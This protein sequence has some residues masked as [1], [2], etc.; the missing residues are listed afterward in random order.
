[1]NPREWTFWC[2][3]RVWKD[4]LEPV[5]PI[6]VTPI[7]KIFKECQVDEIIPY[8][9]VQS[10]QNKI[11]CGWQLVHVESSHSSGF[12]LHIAKFTKYE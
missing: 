3:R 9:F 6:P 10:C 4:T 8:K 7:K 2:G 11:N 1:M 5:T 12:T